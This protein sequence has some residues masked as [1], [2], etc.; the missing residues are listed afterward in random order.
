MAKTSEFTET[1]SAAI[2]GKWDSGN[3]VGCTAGSNNGEY[4]MATNPAADAGG[5]LLQL[6]PADLT[7]SFSGCQV[8]NPGTASVV[9]FYLIVGIHLDGSNEAWFTWNQ[10]TLSTHYTI[11]GV[12]TAPTSVAYSAVDHRFWRIRESGGTMY[13][14]TAGRPG[15]WTVHHSRSN[16]WAVTSISFICTYHTYGIEAQSIATIDNVNIFHADGPNNLG[17]FVTAGSGMSTSGMA[18]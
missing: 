3:D 15:D 14:E 7:G 9:D 5:Y 6:T 12:E 11:A 1:F 2:G 18:N 10:N 13:W 8:T 16:P 4:R 17:R